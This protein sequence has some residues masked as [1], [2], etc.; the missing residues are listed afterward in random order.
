LNK[1]LIGVAVAAL[2]VLVGF[3]FLPEFERRNEL[4]ADLA[5]LEK[6]LASEELVRQQREREVYLLENDTAYVETIARDKLDVMKEGETI[7]RLDGGRKEVTG[8]P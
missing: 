5:A 3:Y 2:V 8:K 1:V 4:G 6:D 7:F